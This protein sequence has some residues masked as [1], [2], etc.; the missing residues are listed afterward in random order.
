VPTPDEFPT[1]GIELTSSSSSGLFK[2]DAPVW[3]YRGIAEG[4]SR[5]RRF[6][7][8]SD[9]FLSVAEHSVFCSYRASSLW[10]DAHKGQDV[11][12]AAASLD[13]LRIVSQQALVHD[14]AEALLGV[15]IPAPLKPIMPEMNILEYRLLGMI[16]ADLG[17]PADLHHYVKV[18]DWQ[19]L[20]IEAESIG[21]PSAPLF[22]G[23][24]KHRGVVRDAPPMPLWREEIAGERWLARFM[25][26]FPGI[27]VDEPRHAR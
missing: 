18:A 8:S 13:L 20:F 14:A 7:C 17:L 4:L 12:T 3:T 1:T 25:E 10:L 15:D 5:L 26:L 9:R 16:L 27:D 2:V 21:L 23:Y 24:E 6:G 19:Q 11:H 22:R